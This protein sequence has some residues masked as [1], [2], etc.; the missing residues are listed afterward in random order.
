MP[1]VGTGAHPR[2]GSGDVRALG[3]RQVYAEHGSFV[4]R[5]AR[6]QRVAAAEVEDVVHDVFLVVHA[7]LRDFD[8]ERATLR[9]WLYGIS[10]RVIAQRTEMGRLAAR[11]LINQIEAKNAAPSKIS[12]DT[13]LIVRES[14]APYH[15]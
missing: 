3:I 10:R 4:A 1:R 9:S 8:P 6:H 2:L 7:R 11:T 5:C 12:L 14:C 15:A 13:R